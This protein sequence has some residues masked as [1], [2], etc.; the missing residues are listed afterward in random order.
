M[1]RLQPQDQQI[2]FYFL[3]RHGSPH[4]IAPHNINYRANIAALQSLG[5]THILAVNAVGSID[6]LLKP[7]DIVLPFQMIDY[8]HGRAT[9]FFDGTLRPLDHFDF[10]Q[11]FDEKLLQQVQQVATATGLGLHLGGVYG[12]TQGPRL[13]SAAEIKRMAQDG[14]TLVG[15]TLMPEAVLAR[16]ADIAYITLCLVVNPAAGVTDSVI[17]LAQ[18]HQ[19]IEQ[20]MGRIRTLLKA[21][22]VHMTAAELA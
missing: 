1:L 11:P 18:I 6:P 3:P 21:V 14:A 22:L 17:T 16:E 9:S 15:M 8:T 10:S 19:A 7:Q 4:R 20:G 2:E 5:V 13:E 12:V